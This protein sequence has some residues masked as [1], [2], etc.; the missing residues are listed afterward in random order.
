MRRLLPWLTVSAGLH[1]N[2]A[3]H[4]ALWSPGTTGDVESSIFG[5]RNG[6]GKISSVNRKYMSRCMLKG[7]GTV[8]STMIKKSKKAKI[9]EC[10]RDFRTVIIAGPSS[11]ERKLL[12]CE[13]QESHSE[14]A[15]QPERTTMSNSVNIN[16][17]LFKCMRIAV[18]TNIA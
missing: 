18:R 6:S 14:N 11:C 17:S 15:H 4:T 13:P 16:L 12:L 3:Q 8:K 5:G 1:S 9:I 10:R 2:L 7:E